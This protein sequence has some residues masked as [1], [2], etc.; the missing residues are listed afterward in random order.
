MVMDSY[1]TDMLLG[2][3]A[4]GILRTQ[5][6]IDALPA[7]YTILGV[8]PQLGMLNYQDIRGVNSDKPDGKITADDQEISCRLQHFSD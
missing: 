3:V 7:G 4:T 2:Y 1:N 8:A 5:A 6:D